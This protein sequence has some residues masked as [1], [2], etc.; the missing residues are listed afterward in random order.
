M[1]TITTKTI[2]HLDVRVRDPLACGRPLP[3]RD[4]LIG[5]SNDEHVKD[6]L[7]DCKSVNLPSCMTCLSLKQP[8]D[9]TLLVMDR[10]EE[11]RVVAI[12]VAAP[13]GP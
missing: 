9:S 10:D 13:H 5:D 1:R 7:L 8:A 2:Q 12:R 6:D 4:T 3:G 11:R